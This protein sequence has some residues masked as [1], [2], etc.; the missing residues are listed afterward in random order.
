[1]IRHLTMAH[2]KRKIAKI[3]SPEGRP[4]YVVDPLVHDLWQNASPLLRVLISAKY[5]NKWQEKSQDNAFLED[6]DELQQRYLG[7]TPVFRSRFAIDKTINKTVATTNGDAVIPMHDR[8]EWRASA[9]TSS[10]LIGLDF[11]ID[12][13]ADEGQVTV[14]HPIPD[15]AMLGMEGM[16]LG[17]LVSFSGLFPNVERMQF[18]DTRRVKT[19]TD[20]RIGLVYPGPELRIPSVSDEEVKKAV[21]AAQWLRWAHKVKVWWPSA[22]APLVFVASILTYVLTYDA[23]QNTWARALNGLATGG[24]GFSLGTIICDWFLMRGYGRRYKIYNSMHRLRTLKQMEREIAARSQGD[25]A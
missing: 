1:M 14:K 10:N 12:I 24:F 18:R 5:Q 7:I 4:D 8:Y 11:D 25:Q 17:K 9:R 2:A 22:W 23:D 16:E 21:A 6:V 19:P 13:Y 20:K 15:G 3:A